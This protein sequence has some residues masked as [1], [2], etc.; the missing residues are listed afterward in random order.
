MWLGD[1]YFLAYA[2]Q[3]HA[4]LATFDKALHHLARKQ[5]CRGE[6]SRAESA[7]VPRHVITSLLD[8]PPGV[9]TE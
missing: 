5:H 7:Q 9:K 1:C 8:T 6:L 2:K 4:T 3:S